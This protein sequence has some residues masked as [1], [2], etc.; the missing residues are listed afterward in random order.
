MRNFRAR[1]LFVLK[2]LRDKLSLTVLLALLLP[3]LLG[4]LATLQYRWLGEISTAERERMQARL[5]TDARRFGQDFNAE[6]TKA[7]FAF[8]FD[9]EDAED[10]DKLSERYAL[11]Q[12]Q[13]QFS[14]LVSEI[15]VT[16]ESENGERQLTR[17][18]VAEKQF[19]AGSWNDELKPLLDKINDE[20]KSE[21]PLPFTRSFDTVAPEIPAL[22][23]PFFERKDQI[24]PEEKR[25][26]IKTHE[27]NGGNFL[28]VKL[29]SEAIKNEVIPELA[30]RHFSDS[31]FAFAIFNGNEKE[32]A[33]YQSQENFD[34]S[35]ADAAAGFFEISPDSSNILLLSS[36]LPRVQTK[37]EGTIVFQSK[38]ERREKQPLR[39]K[40]TNSNGDLH[41]QLSRN[42][43]KETIS[44][45]REG[46]PG[47]WLLKVSHADGS[48]ESF[49]NKTR[50]H[51]LGISFGMLALLGASVVLLIVSAHRATRAAQ[52][53]LDF[54]SSV[55]HEFRTPVAVICSA[56]DNLADGIVNTPQQIER[57]G[58]LLRREGNRL[59][60]MVEQILE[61]AGAR[62]RRKK[63][64]FQIVSIPTLIEAV[65][66]DCQPV[67]EEKDFTV[68]K[69]ITADLPNISADPNALKQ[70]IQNLVSNALKYSNGSRWIK[71]SARQERGRVS[72]SVEDK[73]FGIEPR[74]LRQ[75]F[76]PFYRGRK[77]VSEQI[78]G[79]GLGLSLVK[80]IIEAH[81]G[82]IRVKSETG[83]GS[84]FTIE[85]PA[86]LPEKEPQR[87]IDKEIL[88]TEIL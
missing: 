79:N 86:A 83:K 7:F 56:G 26:T 73:G 30:R 17:Y 24:V 68:E 12:K 45:T 3:V 77:A 67:I 62:S 50:W 78:H 85:I 75:I 66:A 71:I 20:S 11:W 47:R 23:I 42:E 64:D 52:R 74:E 34:F 70:S 48:L 80:Q 49:V 41:F 2:F 60:E 54:V 6:M 36:P 1:I 14:A 61:F 82:E 63:Y 9:L 53:Q 35:K 27:I 38:I 22:L 15:Y 46:S 18:D 65:L 76:E 21:A 57:Y 69:Q 8:Q 39:L 58:K 40:G 25:I 32:K 84:R 28:I 51:N 88:K 43:E 29:N 13:T 10:A 4:V 72:I 44:Y 33:I 37:K 81:G 31:N 55:T 5:Q 59:T 19:S 16:K 87:H